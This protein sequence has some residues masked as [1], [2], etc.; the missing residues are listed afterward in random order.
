MAL[1]KVLVFS[2]HLTVTPAA[3]YFFYLCL[4]FYLK[5]NHQ[6]LSEISTDTDCQIVISALDGGPAA[7]AGIQ[8]GDELLQID[9]NSQTLFFSYFLCIDRELVW[10]FV[11]L[12]IHESHVLSICR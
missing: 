10:K 5:F 6:T 7:R 12:M 2:L 1:S 4:Q 9:G 11:K 8:S 3:W